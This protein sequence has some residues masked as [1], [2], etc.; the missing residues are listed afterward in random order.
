MDDGTASRNIGTVGTLQAPLASTRQRQRKSPLLMVTWYPSSVC[1][2]DA[3]VVRV[4]TGAAAAAAKPATN[5]TTSVI[6]MKP[7]GSAPLY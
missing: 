6:V 1:R 3:T 5:S 4:R 7:S 2:T